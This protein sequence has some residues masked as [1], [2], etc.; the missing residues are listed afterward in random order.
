MYAHII[1]LHRRKDR[2][3]DMYRQVRLIDGLNYTFLEA[4]DGNEITKYPE[5]LG[6]SS[7]Y[8]CLQSHIKAI[9]MAKSKKIKSILICEDDIIFCDDFM[10]KFNSVFSKIPSDWDMIY[11]AYFPSQHHPTPSLLD[12]NISRMNGQVGA[13]C[14]MINDSMYDIIISELQKEDNFV[15]NK[16]A[17]IQKKCNAYSFNKFLCYVKKDYSD[18]GECIVDYKIIKDRFVDGNN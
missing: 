15:D 5:L 17:E 12:D 9:K 16:L 4:V 10:E 14:Y 3:V 2:Y 6:T 7:K 18:L 8:A 1:N 13:F 11:L